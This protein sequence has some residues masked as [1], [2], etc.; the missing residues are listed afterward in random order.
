M[1]IQAALPEWAA[2]II[3]IHFNFS[4]SGGCT[5]PAKYIQS[6][7][8]CK[9]DFFS[10]VNHWHIKQILLRRFKALWKK[11]SEKNADDGDTPYLLY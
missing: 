4:G 6:R 11:L 2:W 5:G 1:L 7:L 9:R 3:N 10:S 8:L